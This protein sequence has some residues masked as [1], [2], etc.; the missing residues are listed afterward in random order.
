[1][2]EWLA[3]G[4]GVKHIHV[5]LVCLIVGGVCMLSVLL[6]M[7]LR[8]L[9]A[10]AVAGCMSAWMGML[11]CEWVQV[12]CGYEWSWDDVLRGVMIPTLVAVVMCVVYW[13]K[14]GAM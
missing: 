3:A 2:I 1:M 6:S 4:N 12:Q 13:A 9:T 11:T 8:S 5:G 10:A 7:D 14:G